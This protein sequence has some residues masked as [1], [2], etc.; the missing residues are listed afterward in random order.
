MNMNT[1]HRKII[2]ALALAATLNLLSLNAAQ[3]APSSKT[4][5]CCLKSASAAPAHPDLLARNSDIAASPKVLANL[6]QLA[7]RH[8]APSSQP[9]M[10]CDCCK[11]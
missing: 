10:A 2:V 6:P 9:L 5:T 11:P 8:Q 7:K 1:K 3:P 4:A